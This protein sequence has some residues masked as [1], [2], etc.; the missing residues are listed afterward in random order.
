MRECI[1][2]SK[3]C[4][5]ATNHFRQQK[6]AAPGE[7][8]AVDVKTTSLSCGLDSSR[9]LRWKIVLVKLCKVSSYEG[10]CCCLSGGEHSSWSLSTP[11]LC[12]NHHRTPSSPKVAKGPISRKPLTSKKICKSTHCSKPPDLGM[13]KQIYCPKPCRWVWHSFFS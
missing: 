2:G 7:L 9:F 1:V 4:R 11:R 10:R 12:P 5:A 6:G 3:L 13:C 8:H